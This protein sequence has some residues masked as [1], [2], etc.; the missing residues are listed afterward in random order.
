ME[1][2][3]ETKDISVTFLYS[4]LDGWSVSL[5]NAAPL[6]LLTTTKPAGSTASLAAHPDKRAPSP[7][8]AH[9]LIAAFLFGGL[10]YKAPKTSP[11]GIPT[12]LSWLF[13]ALALNN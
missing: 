5:T 13:N 12:G 11:E 10:E 8:M 9:V 6:G 3:P 1:L 4:R 7:A 2:L